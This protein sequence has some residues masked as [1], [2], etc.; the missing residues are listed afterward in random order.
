[1]KTRAVLS[2][3]VFRDKD[4]NM[5]VSLS[6]YMEASADQTGHVLNPYMEMRATLSGRILESIYGIES[7]AEWALP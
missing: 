3:C 5:G 2:G 1:M 4:G 7:Y 6:P